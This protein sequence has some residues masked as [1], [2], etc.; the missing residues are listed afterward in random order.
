MAGKKKITRILISIIFIALGVDSVIRAF[1]SLL[2][3]DIGGVLACF[4]RSY[5]LA[6]PCTPTNVRTKNIPTFFEACRSVKK[7]LYPRGQQ[8]KGGEISALFL[9]LF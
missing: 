9:L 4:F 3:L 1:E 8:K 7:L 2:A 5:T 6:Y